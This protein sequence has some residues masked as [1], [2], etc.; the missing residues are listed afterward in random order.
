MTTGG[1][2]HSES[3]SLHVGHDGN[4]LV[5]NKFSGERHVLAGDAWKLSFN[6][7]GFGT[8]LCGVTHQRLLLKNIFSSRVA[9]ATRAGTPNQLFIFNDTTKRTTWWEDKRKLFTDKMFKMAVADGG[10]HA[11]FAVWTLVA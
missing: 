1:V 2:P 10:E 7:N 3:C 11:E 5:L 4:Q 8:L 6:S 9:R